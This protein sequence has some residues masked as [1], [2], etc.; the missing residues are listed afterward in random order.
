MPGPARR[1]AIPG[2]GAPVRSATSARVRKTVRTGPHARSRAA[3]AGQ[4]DRLVE[5][6]ARVGA[7][8]DVAGGGAQLAG[9]RHERQHEQRRDAEARPRERRGADA[10]EHRETAIAGTR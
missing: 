1:R 4:P 10:R 8:R 7:R 2:S 3:T 9:V 5:A 6:F